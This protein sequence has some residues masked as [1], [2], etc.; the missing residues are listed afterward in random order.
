[1]PA[2]LRGRRLPDVPHRGLHEFNQAFE[3]QRGTGTRRV[4]Q[5]HRD[6]FDRLGYFVLPD[7]FPAATVAE[8]VAE[9]DPIERR[10]AELVARRRGG[11]VPVTEWTITQHLVR[12]S[13][14]LRQL[15]GT[16]P[17]AEVALDLL[18][19][20][21]R[22]Y[23]DQ[24][25]YKKPRSTLEFAWHQDNG[26]TFVEPQS[27]LTCWIALTDAD[28]ENGCPVIAVG[29]HR[30]G[31]LAHWQGEQG[32]TC[33]DGD[34]DGIP[35]PLRAGSVAVFSS[36]TVHKTGP[37]RTA[38][39]RKAYVVQYAHAQAVA[40]QRDSEGVLRRVPQNDTDR[41]FPVTVG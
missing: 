21:A 20:G 38:A 33:F 36:V 8:M 12:R 22:L 23:W 9:I 5:A 19:D 26:K 4:T 28:E 29:Q 24:S 1:M 25:V 17:L 40:L 7:V 14:L 39:T 37:N 35:V 30:E 11:T 2:R 32:W 13:P 27:Y 41:Q 16:G 15:C 31:T 3:W 18:G 6:T 34:A 10:A